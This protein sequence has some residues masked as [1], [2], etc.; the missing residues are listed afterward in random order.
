MLTECVVNISEGRNPGVVREVVN[1]LEQ[2]GARVLHVDSGYGAH[3]TVITLVADSS[4]MPDAILG[5]YAV[6]IRTI[7]MNH[8]R[9]CHPR[10]GAVDVCPFIPLEGQG[11]R[12]PETVAHLQSMCLYLGEEIARRFD[13]PVYLYGLSAQ[14]TS[15]SAP[16]VPAPMATDKPSSKFTLPDRGELSFLRKG[17]FEG[18]ATR[19][20]DVQF[21]PDFGPATPHPTAG[22][23]VLGV[24]D[25]LVA[26]NV[27]LDSKDLKMAKRGA[28]FMRSLPGVKALGWHIPEYDSVQISCNITNTHVVSIVDVY[29]QAENFARS[30][31]VQVKGSELIGLVPLHNLQLAFLHA[32]QL[33]E[34]HNLE[35]FISSL[36]TKLGLSLHGTFEPQNRV[37]EWVL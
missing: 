5:M 3:R 12:S 6:S 4:A 31:S 27:T 10:I 30:Q 34:H 21:T 18:L 37:L 14:I 36:V 35:Q 33:G 26:Y 11:V 17:G 2:R 24:R 7:D 28:S 22:A 20:T 13:L 15:D 1:C 8:H 25:F 16:P 23:T 29:K 32:Q 19:M 9:G